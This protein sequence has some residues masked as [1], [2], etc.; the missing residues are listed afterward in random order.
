MSIYS[1]FSLFG[2]LALFL[3]GMNMMGDGL[4]KI[5]GG[6]LEQILEKMTDKTYKGV[7][8]GCAVTAVIQSSSAVTVMVVGFVNSGIMELSRAI[9]VIMGANI[10]T[11]A[12]A[13]IL[14]LTG[15]DGDSLIVNL[16]KPSSFAPVLAVIGVFLL[17]FSKSDKRK[18][19]GGI[20]AGFGILM[21]GM[22]FMSD[23]MS[24]LA[25]NQQFTS[26]LLKFSNPVL[27][28][29]AGMILTA[30]IQSSSASIGILQALSLTGAVSFGTAFPIVLGQNIGTCVT[31]L[32]A[33]VGTN[34]NA[35]RA[36]MAHLYFNI[37][38]VVLAVALFYGGNAIF[39][40]DFLQNTVM[41]SQIAIIHSVFNIFSTLVMLPFTK[42]L[43]K[44]AYM[45]IKDGKKGKEDAPVLL[46]ER[47][48]LTPSYAVEKSREVTVQM[49]DLVEKTAMTAFSLLKNYKSEK[50][51]KISENEKKT[52]KYEEMLETYL[53]KVSALQLS[54]EDSKNVF[55]LHHAIEDLEKISDYCEDIL[56]IKKN[57]NKKNII[58]SEK[59]K[60]DLSVML[61]AV[62]KII[63][64]TVEAFKM[65]DITKAREIEPLE[66]VIDKLK[67]ELKNRHLK[68]IEDGSC[69]VDQGFVFL[70]VINALERIADHCASL[71]VS[72]IELES[73]E[74][75]VHEYTRELKESDKEFVE[76]LD[77]YLEKYSLN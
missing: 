25:D 50:A 14:S 58:F 3:Y 48:L 39:Q 40:F 52:D 15:I 44:L 57:I 33:S 51:S 66:E 8:L 67:K 60:Y 5:S 73:G 77:S 21:M 28:I 69:S 27:G 4:E 19:I 12:T 26:I 63:N 64:L 43:E 24:G 38:G 59:A 49:A 7:L 29:L 2:G 6:K 18:N 9:G 16:L 75:N 71:A 36:A 32:I 68:R 70:D 11:T 22:E 20:I 65:N 37:I 42:Q 35:K 31:A 34:K 76:N 23:S 10:G 46:D 53:V 30:I 41:P 45:T 62:T 17:M 56:K 54:D 47:F 74:Y 55:I 1:I 61:A 72:M 13:W